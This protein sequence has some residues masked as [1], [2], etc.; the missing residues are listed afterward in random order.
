MRSYVRLSGVIFG[1]VSLGHLLRT[2]RRWPLLIAGQPI[3]AAVSLVVCVA[4]G[5]MAFWAWRVLSEPPTIP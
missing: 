4:A 2:V 5:A 3:P 1:L